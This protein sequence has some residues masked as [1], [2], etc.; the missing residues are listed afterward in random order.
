MNSE[1]FAF[2]CTM[3]WGRHQDRPSQKLAGFSLGKKTKGSSPLSSFCSSSWPFCPQSEPDRIHPV[4]AIN[5]TPRGCTAPRGVDGR[6]DDGDGG[7]SNDSDDW[8]T[9]A[10]KCIHLGLHQSHARYQGKL[11]LDFLCQ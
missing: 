3:I 5:K 6:D 7:G 10:K 9:K 2:P 11:G 8:V 1:V 4:T